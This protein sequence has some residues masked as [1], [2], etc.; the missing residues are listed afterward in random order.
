MR[1]VQVSHRLWS[2]CANFLTGSG[3]RRRPCATPSSSS[4]ARTSTAV[5]PSGRSVVPPPRERIF[6]GAALISTG[7]RDRF[8]FPL[9]RDVSAAGPRRPPRAPRLAAVVAAR[10]SRRARPAAARAAAPQRGSVA[11][12]V[13]SRSDLAGVN[14][15]MEKRGA[16]ICATLPRSGRRR[17]RDYARQ[18]GSRSRDRGA[19]VDRQPRAQLGERRRRRGAL[20]RARLPRGAGGRQRV[21]CAHCR[22]SI[23]CSNRVSAGAA[24]RRRSRDPDLRDVCAEALT[25][26][27]ARLPRGHLALFASRPPP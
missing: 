15:S 6:R 7:A 17:R 10:G 26:L 5:V 4:S 14:R 12:E 27:W 3:E 22:C 18:P 8:F 11:R 20:M 2:D 1:S 19:A 13:A 25:A 21:M 9:A 24:A 16:L 23:G